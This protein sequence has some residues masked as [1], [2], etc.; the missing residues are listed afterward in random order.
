M[1]DAR[2]AVGFSSD[3]GAFFGLFED[4]ADRIAVVASLDWRIRIGSLCSEKNARPL[5]PLGLAPRAGS[6]PPKPYGLGLGKIASRAP[7]QEGPSP[8]P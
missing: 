7:P 2:L 6:S 8:N 3:D 5:W 4:R 1:P